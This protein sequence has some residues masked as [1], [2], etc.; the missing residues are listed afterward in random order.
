M[1]L[2]APPEEA[3]LNSGAPKYGVNTIMPSSPQLPPRSSAAS[4]RIVAVSPSTEIFFN[5]PSAK[6]PSDC[7]SGEKK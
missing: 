3:T 2:T 4:Q 1:A 7:P 5:L 6:N